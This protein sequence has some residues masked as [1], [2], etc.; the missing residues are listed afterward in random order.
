MSEHTEGD[1]L[2]TLQSRPVLKKFVRLHEDE[3]RGRTVLLAPEQVLAPNPVAIEVLKL[4][5]GTRNVSDIARALSERYDADQQDIANDIL[6]VL[7]GLA[8]QGLLET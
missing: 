2:V 7:Q 4:C 5:D 3:G 6:P 1:H 8:D